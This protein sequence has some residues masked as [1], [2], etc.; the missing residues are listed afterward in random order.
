MLNENIDVTSHNLA[1]IRL[2]HLPNVNEMSDNELLEQ[3]QQYRMSFEKL[4]NT[5]FTANSN[6]PKIQ[7]NFQ[8][9][10]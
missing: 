2:N 5:D 7:A 6:K 10:K 8:S 9:N 4:S 1:L 3:Y